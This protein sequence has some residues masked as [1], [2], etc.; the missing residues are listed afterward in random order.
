MLSLSLLHTL[1]LLSY[2]LFPL[3]LSLPLSPYLSPSPSLS[4]SQD[5][6][7]PDTPQGRQAKQAG[8]GQGGIIPPSS[9]PHPLSHP[10]THLPSNRL[11]SSERGGVPAAEVKGGRRGRREEREREREG[12]RG[13]WC[14][15][16]W[17]PFPSTRSFT[18]LLSFSLS[19]YY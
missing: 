14:S 11:S 3:C 6:I 7:G 2:A 9:N 15:L 10:S 17:F 19:S 1:S 12:R 13:A 8:Y 16:S 5:G 18:L 4:L